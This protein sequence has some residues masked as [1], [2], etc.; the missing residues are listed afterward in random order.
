MSKKYYAVRKGMKVGIVTSWEQCKTLISGYSGAEY[1]GFNTVEEAEAY[2][3]SDSS[4]TSSTDNRKAPVS[5]PTSDDVVNIY[6]SSSCQD[7]K[8]SLGIYL[9]SNKKQWQLFGVVDGSQYFQMSDIAGKLLDVLVGVQLAFKLGFTKM[10][11]VY[12]Y[13]GVELWYTGEWRAKGELQRL[14]T[15][16]LHQLHV[17]YGVDYRFIDAGSSRKADGLIIA[18]QMVQRARNFVR[19]IDCNKI[20]KG[21]LDV[22]DVGLYKIV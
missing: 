14:Y 21:T 16:L 18:N 13:Q 17:S 3:R 1:K 5:R 10:N 2:M 12:N 20:L 4:S 6:T 8:V 19:Y 7:G 9:E 15:S 22:G 11:I